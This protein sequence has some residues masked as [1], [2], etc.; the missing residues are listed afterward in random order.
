VRDKTAT[1]ASSSGAATTVLR[2]A[3]YARFL[4]GL[5]TENRAALAARWGPPD[6]DPFFVDGAFR[7][8]IH[9]FG[10]VV[11][12]VQPSRGTETSPRSGVLPPFSSREPAGL[13]QSTRPR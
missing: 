2:L 9:R 6:A 7:L 4:A 1:R 8:A 5:P 13:C 12:A 10:N 3:E 11:I